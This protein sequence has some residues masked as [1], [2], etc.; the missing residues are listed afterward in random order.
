MGRSQIPRKTFS[1]RI[2]RSLLGACI[3]LGFASKARKNPSTRRPRDV[4]GRHAPPAPSASTGTQRWRSTTQ[5]ED[6]GS[7]GSVGRRA[8]PPKSFRFLPT[9]WE[10]HKK[11]SVGRSVT[12]FCLVLIF[13]GMLVFRCCFQVLFV[14]CRSLLSSVLSDVCNGNATVSDILARA[15]DSGMEPQSSVTREEPEPGHSHCSR[16]AMNSAMET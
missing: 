9:D 13:G 6:E 3:V 4:S 7:V 15:R 2:W 12:P 14:G 1:F 10:S 5:A 8:T 16:W 11:P